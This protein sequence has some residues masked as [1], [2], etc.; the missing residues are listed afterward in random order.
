MK[1]KYLFEPLEV[2]G[3]MFRNRI[4]SSPQGYY[5]VP[6]DH[7][8]GK[9]A[10]DFFERKAVGGY[11]SV[12]IAE[13]CVD[14]P[15]GMMVPF[16]INMDD[17]NNLPSLSAVAHAITRHG[18]VAA[19][20]LNHHGMYSQQSVAPLRSTYISDLERYKNLCKGVD[21]DSGILYGPVEM[22]HGKYGYV[23][24]M[25][26]EMIE[27]I[28][29]KFGLAAKWAVRC[30]YRQI[31]VHGGHGW[32]LAQFMSPQINTRKDKWGG[33][34]ENRMRMPIAVCERIRKY[35][36][37]KIPIEF[38]F[39]GSECDPNGYDIDEGVKIAMALD[40]KVDILHVSAGN[41]EQ[42]D[43]FIITHPSMFLE[44]GCNVRFA[45]EIKKHVKS[46]V[47]TVGALTD[48]EQMEEIIASGQA[49]IVVLGRQTLAD[50]DLPVK[51]KAGREDEINKCMRCFNCFAN[52]FNNR[53][54]RCAINPA[55]QHEAEE[56]AATSAWEKKKVLIIGGGVGGMQAAL[57]CAK[58]GH[59]VILCEK[60]DRLGGVLTCEEKVP[61]KY[62]LDEYL[63]R[64]AMLVK[65]A[66]ID[67]RLC[68]EVTPELAKSFKA[69]V[70]IAAIGAKPSVPPIPGIDK[71]C[72]KGAEELY[73]DP[74]ACGEKLTIIGGGLV[75]LEL[76]VFM[77]MKGK[78]V[79]VVE[80]LDQFTTQPFSMHTDAL[81]VQ[82]RDR[83]IKTHLS[84]KTLEIKDGAVV[85]EDKDGNVFE[86]PS[87]TVAYA[88]G[89]IPKRAESFAFDDCAPEFHMIGDCQ[90]PQ[91]IYAAT[92]AAYAVARDIGRIF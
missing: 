38:R 60:E 34:F 56:L 2:R 70:I 53:L 79:T 78:D 42:Q 67:V 25:S 73:V 18:A 43:T 69:D 29:E 8:V 71:D 11:A 9:E 50:P 65:R 68:T 49:D 3:V 41:H 88:T 54:L 77:S 91:N 92:T 7:L 5:N 75:G 84:T 16:I 64:Q 58:R 19:A 44:D 37:P 48:P 74:D 28:I 6:S 17:S 35:V 10:I 1:Y 31:I 30:G 45:A 46:Y 63:K 47:A 80:M 4:F 12:C 52:S 22:E 20:E 15:T 90:M 62:H 51:A 13:C 23:H 27:Q 81:R 87:D 26:E 61:F 36:G 55:L 85:C 66:N 57:T 33:S 14:T 83:K 39:S 21:L 72:V 89:M 40:E 86:I 24:E 76:A 59:K 82:I 32:G